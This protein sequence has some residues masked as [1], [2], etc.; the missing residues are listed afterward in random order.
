MKRQAETTV[1]SE[2]AQAEA[3]RVTATLELQE[4]LKAL[5]V[6]SGQLVRSRAEFRHVR[7]VVHSSRLRARLAQD[8]PPARADRAVEAE[9]DLVDDRL[10]ELT[11]RAAELADARNLAHARRVATEFV[12]H[13]ATWDGLTA[14]LARNPKIAAAMDELRSVLPDFLALRDAAMVTASHDVRRMCAEGEWTAHFRAWD[15]PELA[16]CAARL[17]ER[18]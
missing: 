2:E 18:P 15:L 13:R 14:A 17:S 1:A 4:L 12:A 11:T 9:L 8:E 7:H 3:G 5:Q 6:E 16:A 10:A